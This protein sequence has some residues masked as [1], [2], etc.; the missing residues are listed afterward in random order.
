MYKRSAAFVAACK[1]GRRD[2][3]VAARN[4]F[5]TMLA[6]IVTPLGSEG[7][8]LPDGGEVPRRRWRR[9]IIHQEEGRGATNGMRSKIKR[10]P[11]A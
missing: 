7:I 3:E 9:A 6:T 2:R 10:A 8:D 1:A 4:V 11:A 5:R